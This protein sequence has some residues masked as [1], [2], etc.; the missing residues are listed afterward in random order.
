MINTL[1][2]GVYKK[3]MKNTYTN[4]QLKT[5]TF[6]KYVWHFSGHHALTG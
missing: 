1:M 6:F 3:V 2:R 4:L 5:Q